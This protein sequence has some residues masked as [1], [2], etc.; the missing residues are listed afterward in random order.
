MGVACHRY[1]QACVPGSVHRLRWEARVGIELWAE[2]S[3]SELLCA[4]A[5]GDFMENAGIANCTL[6][7]CLNIFT[8]NSKLKLTLAGL[9]NKCK[10]TRKDILKHSGMKQMDQATMLKTANHSLNFS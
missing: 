9:F 7:G 1:G 4:R 5:V 10:I 8:L 2:G 3:D 6:E